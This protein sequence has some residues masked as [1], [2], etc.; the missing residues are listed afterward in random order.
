[1]SDLTPKQE[2]FVKDYLDTGN[3]TEAAERNYDVKDRA[4]AGQIGYEN[5]RKLEIQ[6]A[7]QDAAKNAFAQIVALSAGAE[8]EAVRLNASKDIVDR[9]GFKPVE[10]QD[11]TSGDKPL[12]LLNAI[13]HNDSNKE[14]SEVNEEN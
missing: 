9:A 4:S 1:M 7:I 14:S 10:R 12:P 3:A 6:N 5:L 11:I 8:N 2:G 13:F